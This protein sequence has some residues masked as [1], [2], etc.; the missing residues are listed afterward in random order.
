MQEQA[1][2]KTNEVDFDRVH[3]ASHYSRLQDEELAKLRNFDLAPA[4]AE[5]LKQE[6]SKRSKEKEMERLD[7]IRKEEQRQE[8]NQQRINLGK[9]PL[10][11]KGMPILE[12]ILGVKAARNYCL[13]SIIALVLF[14]TIGLRLSVM[15]LVFPLLAIWAFFI[16]K[17]LSRNLKR[18]AIQF[19]I[20]IAVLA[21]VFVVFYWFLD[22]STTI[23]SAR[24]SDL[25]G[26]AIQAIWMAYGFWCALILAIQ[27]IRKKFLTDYALDVK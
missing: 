4:V 9:V 6:L 25:R 5:I 15:T 7:S 13:Y 27:L 1:E 26:L 18:S 2:S 3:I 22:H 12:E 16:R 10:D 21:V 19:I 17:G 8:E 23:Q 24:G 14:G 20:F 11:S